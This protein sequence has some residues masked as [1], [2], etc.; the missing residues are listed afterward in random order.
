MFDAGGYPAAVPA[1]QPGQR[2]YGEV[3]RIP[4]QA[5]LRALDTFEGCTSEPDID[6]EYHRR[7]A[8]VRLCDGREVE[9]WVYFYAH[10]VANLPRIISGDFTCRQ[11]Q[12]RRLFRSRGR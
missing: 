3:Y 8:R 11:R 6:D 1:N 5:V 4:S 9:C 10:S 12:P 7:L 2:V